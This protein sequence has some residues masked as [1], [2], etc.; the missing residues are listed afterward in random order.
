MI[1]QGPTDIVGFVKNDDGIFWE[2]LGNL[3][4]NFGIKQ[5]VEWV[6][7]DIHERHLGQLMRVT[8]R[9]WR[10]SP[11]AGLWSMDMSCFHARAEEH[12]LVSICLGVSRT[13]VRLY[14]S[15]KTSQHLWSNWC[16]IYCLTSCQSHNST[17]PGSARP[18]SHVAEL[19]RSRQRAST[20]LPF[21]SLET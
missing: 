6:D 18:F 2:F 14:P 10:H 17:E 20:T 3:F 12:R 9:Y 5:I 19:V 15:S 21:F 1:W 7:D 4:G 16:K 11:F 8:K 13:Q